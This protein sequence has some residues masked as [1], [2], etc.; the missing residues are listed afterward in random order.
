MFF[1]NYGFD[2]FGPPNRRNWA[3][4]S[5][6]AI[7]REQA[8]IRT[9]QETFL[10]QA[11]Q[12]TSFPFTI[13]GL[14][15]PEN[16]LTDA[17]WRTFKQTVV[18][19]GCTAKRREITPMEKQALRSQ[20]RKGKMYAINVSIAC[21]P[22]QAVHKL[23]EKQA[24]AD[25]KKKEK[26]EAKKVKEQQEKDMK[27]LV[28]QEYNMLEEH[29]FSGQ[30]RSVPAEESEVTGKETNEAPPVAAKKLKLE[31]PI[32]RL[33]QRCDTVYSTKKSDLY[34]KIAKEKATE[35]AKL[36]KELEDKFQEKTKE[37]V[38]KLNEECDYMKQVV[39]DVSEGK[40]IP[41]KVDSSA[42]LDTKIAASAVASSTAASS[43]AIA[44]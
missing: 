15:A 25:L 8:A 29:V 21:H 24:K 4:K 36:L 7:G 33:I 32:A 10:P 22:D 37:E 34:S 16:H 44:Q 31:A 1:F 41:E 42:I 30:K 19:H 3:D 35:K 18:A 5:Q 11:R 20:A 13:E 39:K 27:A 26:E 9:F 17:C 38:A 6:A 43:T 40:D 12:A 28:E 14:I 23:K 2:D